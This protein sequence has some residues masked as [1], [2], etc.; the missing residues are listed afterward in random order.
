MRIWIQLDPYGYRLR[1]SCVYPLSQGLSS[2]SDNN[3]VPCKFQLDFFL[4]RPIHYSCFDIF[5]VCV[6]HRSNTLPWNNSKGFHNL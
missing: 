2:I 3:R 6:N 4:V 5:Y 1:V